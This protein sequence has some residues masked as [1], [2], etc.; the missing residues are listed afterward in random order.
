MKEKRKVTY[1]VS[2]A[3]VLFFMA[4]LAPLRQ[5]GNSEGFIS[6]LDALLHLPQEILQESTVEDALSA[7]GTQWMYTLMPMIASIVS[8]SLVYEEIK[9]KFYMWEEFRK[10]RYRYVY[11]RFLY[12]AV[13]GA[14]MV[15]AGLMLYAVFVYF[16][17]PINAG[18]EEVAISFGESVLHSSKFI[19]Y[20]ALYGMAMSVFASFLVCL[21]QNLYVDLSL[22]F[23]AAYILREIAM[24][25]IILFPLLLVAGLAILYGVMWRIREGHI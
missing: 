18:Y 22:V 4:L 24:K 3:A 6:V 15:V 9:S 14:V 13:S 19:L 7:C 11:S 16:I 23:I 5:V 2:G 1:Y 12:S 20:V 8:A 21:Y 10:G 17:F 25:E